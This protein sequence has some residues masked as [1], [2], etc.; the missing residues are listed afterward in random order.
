[1]KSEIGDSKGRRIGKFWRKKI[2]E[3]VKKDDSLDED[4]EMWNVKCEPNISFSLYEE[5]NH[6]LLNIRLLNSLETWSWEA[7]NE[8]KK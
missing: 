1:M 6:Q 8:K 2:K 5:N 4:G 7:K 3:R